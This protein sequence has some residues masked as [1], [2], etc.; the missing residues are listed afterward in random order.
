MP[1]HVY[2]LDTSHQF[3][4]GPRTCPL[5]STLY[6][7]NSLPSIQ[8]SQCWKLFKHTT[9]R[10]PTRAINVYTELSK[11]VECKTF[12]VAAHTSQDFFLM[13]FLF[14]AVQSYKV[15]VLALKDFFVGEKD[16]L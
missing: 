8:L 6:Q 10:C 9:I 5:Y 11:A 13:L 16:I 2:A 15:L 1:F 3:F 4:P 7:L 14:S 12:S